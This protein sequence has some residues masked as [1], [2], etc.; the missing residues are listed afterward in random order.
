[1]RRAGR[2]RPAVAY[3][4]TRD[5]AQIA[6]ETRFTQHAALSVPPRH[7]AFD[8]AD[9]CKVVIDDRN[10]EHHQKDKAGEKHLLLDLRA[11][12]APRD[13]LERHDEDVPA[14]EHRNGEQVEQAQVEGDRG[15]QREERDP[16]HLRRL[17]RQLRDGHRAHELPR[18]RLADEEPANRLEDETA[19]L[20]VAAN[21]ECERLE[22]TRLERSGRFADLDADEP[23]ITPLLRGDR[24]VHLTLVTPDRE[25]DRTP[26]IPRD[27]IR[28]LAA[29]HHPFA[30]DR[31]HL[32][33]GLDARFL[34]GIAGVDGLHARID[35]RQ[36]ADVADL[37]ALRIGT[38]GQ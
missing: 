27:G 21:A 28:E 33:A 1:K 17:A 29:E 11:E 6:V 14:V 3:G 5:A 37:K 2:G 15:H 30:V 32:I 9:A 20:D 19:E 36:H 35:V 4:N 10:H 24:D 26:R 22:R 34:G 12:V 25:I 23:A 7:Q 31:E 13:P 16:A 38:Y 18:R 8:P